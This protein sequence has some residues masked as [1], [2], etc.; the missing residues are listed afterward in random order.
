MG[1]LVQ[2]ILSYSGTWLPHVHIPGSGNSMG[3]FTGSN[4][5]AWECCLPLLE[6]GGVELGVV[7]VVHP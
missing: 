6:E 4:L 5:G 2:V 3:P 7:T 1:G